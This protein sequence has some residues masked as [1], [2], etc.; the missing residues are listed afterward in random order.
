MHYSLLGGIIFG[1]P[2]FWCC[3]GG[4]YIVAARAGIP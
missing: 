2:G 1:E 4:G 3:L